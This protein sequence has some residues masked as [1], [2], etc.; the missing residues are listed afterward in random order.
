MLLEGSGILWSR[1]KGKVTNN[2][3]VRIVWVSG[4]RLCL[5]VWLTSTG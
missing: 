3:M 2:M 4:V 5:V 1:G